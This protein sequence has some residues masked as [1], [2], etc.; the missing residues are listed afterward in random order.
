MFSEK[1]NDIPAKRD[2]RF[3]FNRHIFG[4]REKEFADS[5]GFPP[6]NAGLKIEREMVLYIDTVLFLSI[7]NRGRH[8][9]LRS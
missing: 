2:D 6:L 7:P 9:Y 1:I 8:T 3:V 4:L 5:A